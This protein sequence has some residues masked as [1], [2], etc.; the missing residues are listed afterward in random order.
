MRLLMGCQISGPDTVFIMC[1][2]GG[3]VVCGWEK[4]GQGRGKEEEGRREEKK[5]GDEEGDDLYINLQGLA[6]LG[7]GANGPPSTL[8]LLK[9]C[10]VPLRA[11]SMMLLSCLYSPLES[12]RRWHRITS[13]G[14]GTPSPPPR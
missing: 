2:G 7:D 1:C 12:R 13:E 5:C 14:V 10:V 9:Y 4:D 11:C 3:G 6:G 8:S